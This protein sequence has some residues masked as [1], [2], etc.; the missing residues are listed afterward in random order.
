MTNTQKITPF[1]L[2]SDNGKQVAESYANIFPNAKILSESNFVTE[3]EIFGTKISTLNAWEYAKNILNPS[4]S[5]SLWITDKELAKQIWTQLSDGWSVMMW[6]DS[7][8]RSKAYW[9]CNDKNWVSRQIMYNDKITQN[10]IISSLMF[11]WANNGKAKEAL[12]YYT[13]IF[14]DS[15]IDNIYPYWDW[16]WETV[17][18]ISHAEFKLA[19]QQFIAMDSSADHKFNFSDW[20]SLMISCDGQEEVDKFWNK[21]VN[22]WWTE[23]QCGWCKDKY[24]VSRQVVP[25]QLMTAISDPTNWQKAMKNMMKMKKIVIADLSK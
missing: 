2:C 12:D 21:F 8:P 1:I 3:L 16:E 24:W 18:N 7:Y 23:S 11:V 25:V 17:W 10:Q 14:D 5:F 22:D 4:I 13:G 6:R 9:R 20:I 19:N 15:K